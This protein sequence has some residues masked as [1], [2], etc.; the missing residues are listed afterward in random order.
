[1]KKLISFKIIICLAFTFVLQETKAITKT[2]PDI[3]V[4]FL[5][6]GNTTYGFHNPEEE[7][8]EDHDS[9]LAEGLSIQEVELYFKSNIDPYW[10]GNVSLSLSQHEGNFDLDLEEA[11]VESLAIPKFTLKMGKYYALFGKHN[12]LHSHHYPFID[13]PLINQEL[14]GFHGWGG[15]GM[16]LSYLAPFSW[17]SEW[18]AQGFVDNHAGSLALYLKNFW[19]LQNQST[20]ELNLS[21]VR[22]Y[23]DYKHL[24]NTAFTLKKTDSGPERQSLG[25]TTELSHAMGNENL[26]DLL[27][28]HSYVQWRFLRNWLIEGRADYLSTDYDIESLDTQKYSLLFVYS[29]TEYSAIRLQFDASY[30]HNV[31]LKKGSPWNYSLMLQANMSLGT[32]PAHLY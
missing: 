18:V 10:T 21:Y 7:R 13:P 15:P 30:L 27:G 8:E 24:Y 31:E 32:H 22:G 20:L 14:F 9:H 28:L 4:N 23:K 12:N 16:A 25:W 1:M 6:L 11:F 26:K 3:S 29:A 5:L 2:N 19:E 17:Y